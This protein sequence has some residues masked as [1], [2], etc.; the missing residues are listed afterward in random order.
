ML[1]AKIMFIHVNLYT[2]THTRTRIHT[3]PGYSLV[4]LESS[5]DPP[6]TSVDHTVYSVRVCVLFSTLIRSVYWHVCSHSAERA[7][8]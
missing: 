8:L 5:K 4:I 1:A 6:E 2:Q 7:Y 3:V